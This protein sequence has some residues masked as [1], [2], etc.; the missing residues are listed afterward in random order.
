MSSFHFVTCLCNHVVATG[1]EFVQKGGSLC[2]AQLNFL[3]P[4]VQPQVVHDPI[5]N[6]TQSDPI[7]PHQTCQATS[8][9]IGPTF[10]AP[11]VLH[12]AV[13]KPRGADAVA[14]TT[15]PHVTPRRALRPHRAAGLLC[16]SSETLGIRAGPKAWAFW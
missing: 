7:R 16:F 11:S 15:S 12:H 6:Q 5:S 9:F 14:P 4:E 3:F 2:F 1:W 8:Q 13:V 10:F